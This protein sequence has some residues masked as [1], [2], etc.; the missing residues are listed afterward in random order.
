[1][2]LI[3]DT[4]RVIAALVKDSTSRKI[5][6]SDKINFLTIEITKQEIEEHD[7]SSYIRLG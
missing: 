5:L 2:R 6:L 7:R 3:V 1:M 4:N